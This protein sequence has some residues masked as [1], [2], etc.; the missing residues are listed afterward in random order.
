MVFIADK[1]SLS[2]LVK[3]LKHNAFTPAKDDWRYHNNTNSYSAT[4]LSS[5]NLLFAFTN[6][7]S[8]L[9]EIWVKMADAR[10][11]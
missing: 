11:H 10:A 9:P 3:G 1:R 7:Q 8:S 6:N 4:C 5:T 2:L